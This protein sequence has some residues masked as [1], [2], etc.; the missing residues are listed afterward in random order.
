[1]WTQISNVGRGQGEGK[2]RRQNRIFEQVS[3]LEDRIKEAISS[4][5]K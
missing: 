1:M 5:Q 3:N 2:E 4:R